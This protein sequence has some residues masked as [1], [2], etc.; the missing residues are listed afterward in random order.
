MSNTV[1]LKVDNTAGMEKG[2]QY[3]VGDI[4]SP[5][6]MLEVVEV[7]DKETLLIKQVS[8]H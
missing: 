3:H 5:I 2:H 7:I 4:G 1:E 8:N 6:M